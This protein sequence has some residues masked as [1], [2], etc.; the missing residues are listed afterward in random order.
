[1]AD[2]A[3]EDIAASAVAEA[4]AAAATPEEGEVRA[5]SNLFTVCTVSK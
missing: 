4:M 1:M 5:A 3:A 2:I